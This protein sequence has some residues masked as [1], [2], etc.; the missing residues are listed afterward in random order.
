LVSDE[1]VDFKNLGLDLGRVGLIV[2]RKL[3]LK[4]FLAKWMQ[5]N[6]ITIT[7]L[8]EVAEVIIIFF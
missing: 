4:N 3:I 1:V 6:M 2:A 7:C 5:E 8:V